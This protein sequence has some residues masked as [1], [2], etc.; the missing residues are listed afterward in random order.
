MFMS[1]VAR[2]RYDKDGICT[3]DGKIRMFPFTIEEPAARSSKNR[4]KG[5]MKVKPI[6]SITKIVVKQ[7]LIVKIIRA[8]KAKWPSDSNKHI[9]IQQDTARPHINDND[10]D[11]IDVAQYDGFHITLANQPANSPD[12]NINDLGFF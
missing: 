9:V 5:V 8:I 11:F 7:C 12:L 4:A 10:L 3:F 2:P 1:A 6:D